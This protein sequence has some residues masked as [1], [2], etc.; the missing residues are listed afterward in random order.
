[1][2]TEHAEVQAGDIPNMLPLSLSDFL[3]FIYLMFN[4]HWRSALYQL[5]SP[6]LYYHPTA[7]ANGVGD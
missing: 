2:H 1:V 7:T 6:P 3:S 5:R 4:K